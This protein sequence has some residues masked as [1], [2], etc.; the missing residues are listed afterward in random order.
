M[1]RAKG[2]ADTYPTRRHEGRALR[3]KIARSLRPVCVFCR[4]W[5]STAGR[6]Y[7]WR[8]RPTGQP[9]RSL[10]EFQR[11]GAAGRPMARPASSSAWSTRAVQVAISGTGQRSRTASTS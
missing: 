2:R 8:V 6:L 4:N 5:C 1:S 11:A 3:R 7:F 9:G 10:Q